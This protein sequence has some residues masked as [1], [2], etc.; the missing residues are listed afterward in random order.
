MNLTLLGLGV[1]LVVWLPAPV[2]AQR[3]EKPVVERAPVLKRGNPAAAPKASPAPT[4]TTGAGATGQPSPAARAT[5]EAE[6]PEDDT[7]GLQG[8]VG[9]VSEGDPEDEEEIQ[10]VAGQVSEGDPDDDEDI[11]ARPGMVG[12][13]GKAQLPAQGEPGTPGPVPASP[14]K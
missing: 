11:Q 6:P 14:R 2:S 13:P 8:R 3:P 5:S 9:I 10:S 12:A 1:A 7:G 4:P